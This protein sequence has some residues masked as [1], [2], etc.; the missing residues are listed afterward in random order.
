[1]VDADEVNRALIRLA[2]AHRARASLLLGSLGLHPGQE[3]LLLSLAGLGESSPGRLAQTLGVEPPTVTKMVAR[4]ESSGVV[5]RRPDP[6]DGRSVLVGL[7]PA[8]ERLLRHVTEAWQQLGDATTANLT[9]AERTT[10]VSLLLRTADS[11]GE[12]AR[13]LPGPL[14]DP[15]GRG[16]PTG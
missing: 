12:E 16:A 15:C 10:F 3:V 5:A 1:M 9:D 7:T 13:C 14:D 8:G 4:L 11:L 2:R 6:A